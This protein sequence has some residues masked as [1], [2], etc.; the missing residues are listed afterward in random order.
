MAGK[1]EPAN[2]DNLIARYEAGESAQKLGGECGVSN[3]TFAGF[4]RSRGIAVRGAAECCKHRRLPPERKPIALLDALIDRYVAGESELTLAN[5]AGVNRGTFRRRLLKRGITPRSVSDSMFIRWQNVTDTQRDQMLGPAHK[6]AKNRVV[7]IEEKIRRA[8]AREAACSN[9]SE[10]ERLLAGQLRKAGIGCT[11]Q[12]AIWKYN[13][14]IAIHEPAIAVELFGGG[15]HSTPKHARGHAERAKH[16]LDAGWNVLIIW[17]DSRRH[18]LSAATREAVVAFRDELRRSPPSRSEYRV[19][20]GNGKPAP[21][22]ENYFNTRAI[23]K[24]IGRGDD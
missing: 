12:K 10:E 17:I 23:V 11:Q 21:A 5:E 3:K 9:A 1:F 15:W 8:A 16:L 2:A 19:I 4:L 6:A 14:D 24:S 18:G 7:P 20:L 22:L 13:I